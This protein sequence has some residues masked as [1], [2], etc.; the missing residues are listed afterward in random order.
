MKEVNIA[1]M[2]PGA[3]EIFCASFSGFMTV[4]ANTVREEG[5][6]RLW[7][8]EYDKWC[9]MKPK[10]IEANYISPLSTDQLSPNSLFSALESEDWYLEH[11]GRF[12]V[13]SFGNINSVVIGENDD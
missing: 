12:N 7:V 1:V 5:E 11:R 13:V 3:V 10:G 6:C 4:V 2:V 9:V 8:N